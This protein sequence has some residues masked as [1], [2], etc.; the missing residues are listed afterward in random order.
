MPNARRYSTP[1]KHTT[2]KNN[3]NA[4]NT[5][6]P[7]AVA[8]KRYHSAGQY[9]RSH[10]DIATR[11]N[12][13]N[14][15]N[16]PSPTGSRISVPSR[17]SYDEGVGVGGVDVGGNVPSHPV[18]FNPPS[19]RRKKNNH[20]PTNPSFFTGQSNDTNKRVKRQVFAPISGSPGSNVSTPSQHR[21]SSS[22]V[23]EN[24]DDKVF[25]QLDVGV[26]LDDIVQGAFV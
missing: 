18:L 12:N 22:V 15:T 10:A 3:E 4:N 19:P 20:R 5:N 2:S 21:N 13:G 25:H 8:G 7:F 16:V 1:G 6:G 24:C 14:T 9:K 11:H 26:T 17:L 23:Y